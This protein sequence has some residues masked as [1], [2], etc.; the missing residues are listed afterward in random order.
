MFYAPST[1]QHRMTLSKNFFFSGAEAAVIAPRRLTSTFPIPP[2]G[3]LF[4]ARKHMVHRTDKPQ[5]L[6]EHNHMLAA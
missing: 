3:D 2:A 6:H 4:C 1:V 5:S